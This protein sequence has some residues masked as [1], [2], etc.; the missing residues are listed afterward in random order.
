MFTIALCLLTKLIKDKKDG[1]TTLLIKNLLKFVLEAINLLEHF[2]IRS[3]DQ[4]VL[5]NECKVSCS[6]KQLLAPDMI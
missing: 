5:S 4:P 3:S 6:R 2:R 1:A